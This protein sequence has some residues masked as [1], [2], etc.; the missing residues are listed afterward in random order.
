LLL[1]LTASWIDRVS[2]STID[3]SSTSSLPITSGLVLGFP[4]ERGPPPTSPHAT[5]LGGLPRWN[6]PP[7]RIGTGSIIPHS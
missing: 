2:P 5:K 6:N 3:S 7:P 4:N 1:I